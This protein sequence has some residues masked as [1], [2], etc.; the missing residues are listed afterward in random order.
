MPVHPGDHRRGVGGG[1]ATR[2]YRHCMGHTNDGHTPRTT[3]SHSKRMLTGP[4]PRDQGPHDPDHD[5][6][7]GE[8]GGGHA[9]RQWYR[10]WPP[11]FLRGPWTPARTMGAYVVVLIT[12]SVLTTAGVVVL[13]PPDPPVKIPLTRAQQADR[14]AQVV[15]DAMERFSEA[16]PACMTGYP[17]P[18]AKAC[19]GS[20]ATLVLG[21]LDAAAN[22]MK[23]AGQGAGACRA[24]TRALA[25]QTRRIRVPLGRALALY[26]ASTTRAQGDVWAKRAIAQRRAWDRV[27]GPMRAACRAPGVT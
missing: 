2:R 22:R 16:A 9:R 11:R 13:S 27:L 1:C 20:E 19:L 17:T 25:T 6:G 23:A 5:Q 10:A 18:Q 15:Y 12:A 14:A 21:R 26:Q 24:R 8:G 4:P 3:T 7:T